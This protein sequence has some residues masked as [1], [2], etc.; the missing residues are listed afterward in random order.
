M[1]DTSIDLVIERVNSVKEDIFYEEVPEDMLF[2]FKF[3]DKDGKSFTL[4]EYNLTKGK[5][6]PYS[7]TLKGKCLAK[8]R[9]QF[10]LH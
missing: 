8:G 6:L 1:V 4:F 3:K 9:F 10:I 2:T 5:E 7:T